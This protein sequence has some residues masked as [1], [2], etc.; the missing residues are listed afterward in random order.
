MFARQLGGFAAARVDNDQAPSPRLERLGLA[1][2]IGHG[3]HAA[4]G[5]H[6][7]AA[8]DDHQF[9][10]LDV[11]QGY[12]EPV[13]EHQPAGQLLG[14]LVEGRCR[15]DVARPQPFGQARAVEQQADL[16]RCWIAEGDGKGVGIA[17]RLQ[18][19]HAPLDL[20]IGFVPGGLD[21]LPVAFDQR[22]AQA[23]GGVVQVLD[24]DT[25]GADVAGG[26]HVPALAAHRGH[27]TAF[28]GERQA[29]AGLAKR[30]DAVRGSGFGHGSS[31]GDEDVVRRA[32]NTPAPSGV[33]PV[34]P[35]YIM[36]CSSHLLGKFG[37]KTGFAEV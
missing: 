11:G 18:R 8:Q 3:P 36:A 19:R 9:G 4:V 33:F 25:L 26:E 2:E 16:V 20:G 31:G 23:V 10:A 13:P 14:H 32:G 1:P 24:R 15:E 22:R 29:A 12:R 35:D 30:A 17:S 21:K 5:R 27:V 34:A 7:V 6:G 28:D 37:P